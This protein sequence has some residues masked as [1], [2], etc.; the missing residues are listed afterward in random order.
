M[1]WQKNPVTVVGRLPKTWLFAYRTPVEVARGLLPRPL[2]PV[3][4]GGWAYWNVVVSR[5]EAMR[6]LGFPALVGVGYWH[7]AY[8]FY[9][10]FRP[11]GDEPIEGLYFVRSDCDSLPMTVAGNLLTDFNFHTAGVRVSERAGTHYLR[12][13]SDEAPAQAAWRMATPPGPAEGSPFGSLDE[14]TVAL[15]YKPN[16]LSVGSDGTVNVV[17]ISRD[18][19]AW[20][21]RL[22]TV[23]AARW[24]FLDRYEIY[25]E[26]CY[27]VA[28]IDYRWNRARV[29]RAE[30]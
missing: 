20:R 16:G 7:V 2:E 26:L 5:I 12:I 14:A 8:R 11:A 21:A 22:V 28:P 6:P 17:R 13:D 25:P 3:V 29:Y 4:F 24:H 18:E 23:E 15:K 27:A 30:S 9:A 1:L 19:A 10:R